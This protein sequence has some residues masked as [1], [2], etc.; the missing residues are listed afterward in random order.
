M[1]SAWEGIAWFVGGILLGLIL[2]NPKKY[3]DL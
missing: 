1:I 3:F 2:S